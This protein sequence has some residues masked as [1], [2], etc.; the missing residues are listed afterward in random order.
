MEDYDLAGVVADSDLF[1][2]L[3]CRFHT[4]IDLWPKGFPETE[5]LPL[6]PDLA[7]LVSYAS[8][9]RRIWAAEA[10]FQW[11]RYWLH[12]KFLNPS[13]SR[14]SETPFDGG[15]IVFLGFYRSFLPHLSVN[16]LYFIPTNSNPIKMKGEKRSNLMGGDGSRRSH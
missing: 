14:I 16:L 4:Q 15:G 10:D 2:T 8:F 7:F 6:L 11:R 12:R 9:S 5:Q 13:A 3:C 1:E